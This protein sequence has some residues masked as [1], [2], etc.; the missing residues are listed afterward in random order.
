[1]FFFSLFFLF[2]CKR[3]APS[4]SVRPSVSEGPDSI[5]PSEMIFLIFVE[6]ALPNP[7]N[8]HQTDQLFFSKEK[9]Q[10]VCAIKGESIFSLYVASLFV[11]QKKKV[12]S[13]VSHPETTST[14]NESIE[15]NLIIHSSRFCQR[16]RA[17][18]HQ[19]DDD[20]K[21]VQQRSDDV[22]PR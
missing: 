18:H 3:S 16:F 4:I 6:V 7:N 9:F 8:H 12:P 19:T 15:T 10:V 13:S 5:D 22:C 17:R 21:G 1:M 11:A 20:S 14:E 2:S